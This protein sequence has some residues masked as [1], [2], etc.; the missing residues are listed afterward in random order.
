M[1][2]IDHDPANHAE[3]N[4]V[5]LCLDHH[6][7][8][9]SSPSQSKGITK[10]EVEFYRDKLYEGVKARPSR[11]ASEKPK[12]VSDELAAVSNFLESV[13]PKQP[14]RS[15]T[16]N[17]YE[18]QKACEWQLLKIEPFSSDHLTGAGY[19]LS[20]GEEAFLDGHLQRFTEQRPLALKPDALVVFSTREFVSLPLWLMG[21]LNPHQASTLRL[22]LYADPP[23]TVGPGFRGRLF[24]SVQN[25][26][27]H[28]ILVAPG[29]PLVTLE[30]C[31]LNIPPRN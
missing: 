16:L 13:S 15:S 29:L 10:E 21:K 18:I 11:Q 23:S 1:A 6:D 28:A 4:L 25:R 9:D 17:G 26:G 8:F 22:G 24:V 5:F 30:F 7:A 31:L 19:R 2:H 12:N 27:T 3:R 20:C 14:F